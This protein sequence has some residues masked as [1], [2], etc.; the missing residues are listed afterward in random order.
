MPVN[1]ACRTCRKC[2]RLGS[3]G[4]VSG[5]ELKP[6]KLRGGTASTGTRKQRG[7]KQE[8]G[9][10]SSGKPGSVTGGQRGTKV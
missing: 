9:A 1:A 4:R 6:A 5:E 2:C 10:R 7:A 8:T 3:A